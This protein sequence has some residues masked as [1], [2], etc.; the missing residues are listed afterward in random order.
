M[1]NTFRTRTLASAI[2]LAIAG[3][4]FQASF[5]AQAAAFHGSGSAA[6]GTQTYVITFSEPGMLHYRGGVQG[7]SATAKTGPGKFNAKSPQALAYSDYLASQRAAHI[8]AIEGAIGRS[9]EI[10]HSYDITSNGIAAELSGAE[11]ARVKQV[12][13]VAKVE[14]DVIYELDTYRGPKFIGADKIWDGTATPNHTGTMGEGVTIGII[15]GG[16]NSTHPS[17]ANDPTCGFSAANPKLTA[18]DCTTSSG[19]SCTGS[20]PEANP[21]YGHG[22]HTSSTAAGN[23]ID[24]T[25]TP[26]PALPNGMTMSGVAPCA[27]IHQ[28]KVCATNNCSGSAITAAINSAIADQVDAI[29]FSISGGTS[30]WTDS[31]RLFLDAV[32]A[33]IFVSA[34]AGNNS[35]DNP[36]VVGMVNHRGPWV[37]SVAASTQDLQV[38][39]TLKVDGPGTPPDVLGGVPLTPGSQSPAAVA[40]SG[41]PLKTFPANIAGCTDGGGIPAGTFTGAIAVL[42]RGPTNVGGTACSFVE[43]VNNAAAAGAVA[44]VIGNNQ[45]GA[46]NMNTDG[47]A[48]VPRFAVGSLATSNALIDFLVANDPS[49][50]GDMI[51]IGAGNTQGDVLADFSY[52]GPTPSPLADLTKPDIT[53]PGVNIYAATDPASGQYEFMSGTSMSSPHLGGSGVLVRAVHPDWTPMEVKS[54]LQTTAKSDGFREDGTTPW[55][56]DDI[57]SGRVDLTKAALAGLTLD[58]TYANFLAANPSG[59]SVNVKTLNLPSMRN[60]ACNDSCTWTR[61]VKNRLTTSGSW[62]VSFEA[63]SGDFNVTASP[64]SFTLAPGATQAITFTAAP[65]AGTTMTDIGFGNVFLKESSG[66]SPDQH[67]TVAVKGT[68]PT[69][70][71]EIFK[72]GFD[73]EGG[74][75]GTVVFSE[76][77]DSYAAGSNAHGQGGWKGWG[78]DEAAGA[79]VV[80]T[81]SVSPSNSIQIADTSDLIHEFSGYTSGQYTV[82]AKMYI[83]ADFTGETYFIFENAYV[84]SADPSILSWSTQVVFR[85]GNVENYDN[86]ADPGS[87]PYV[88]GQWAD[89]ELDI[90]LD[91]DQQTFSYNGAV[92]YSGSWTQ[93][94]PGQAVPG[95][96][97]IASI[98]LYAGDQGSGGASPV[99]YDDIKIVKH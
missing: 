71:D 58:E 38:G 25:V 16:T 95:T 36:A 9:L 61:T 85:N 6:T 70:V 75:E 8:A 86:A 29:S 30:P 2:G 17:F 76:N 33:D 99:Y 23:T 48:N 3:L 79:T 22:V 84:D 52:R 15:D 87:M 10:S 68:G 92:L 20:N 81:Q 13:G 72:D 83:P 57:G 59:G 96:L 89:I 46:L 49:G 19:N 34:S 54:A 53:G 28:Y 93:Q 98:D 65:S 56:T 80:D 55:N 11:A 94:F 40:L 26:A 32:N 64:A 39:P 90:D 47:A 42:R 60:L 18:V 51:P 12:S 45:V 69:I 91:A 62:N 88:T 41:V 67:L 66:Q 5:D 4:G 24:N 1:G 7:L 74:D 21:T 82:T 43:K 97:N 50:T 44:V 37:L 63:T 77:W 73:G 14:A 78:N 35:S 27:S 31:D